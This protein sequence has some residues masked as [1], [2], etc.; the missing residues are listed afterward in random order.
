MP[1]K[2]AICGIKKADTVDHIPPRSIY[3][4]PIGNEFQLKTI[5]ACKTCNN[6]S[7]NEDEQF[8]MWIG[9]A[10]GQF[11]SNSEKI[12]NSMAATMSNNNTLRDQIFKSQKYIYSTYRS[13]IAEPAIPIKFN[14]Q[15]I[16][17][18][19]KRIIRGLYWI[20]KGAAL[21]KNYSV[22]VT[23]SSSLTQ[24]RRTEL[25][26]I[27]RESACKHLNGDTFLYQARF[28]NDDTPSS[29]WFIQFFNVNQTAYFAEIQ[30]NN[31]PQQD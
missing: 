5:P 24:F 29:L 1:K 7:S 6:G 22:I 2:C 8:K 12:I 3:P 19:I 27:L 26:L 16:E 4:R 25:E 23:Q 30:E 18:V 14:Q 17:R 11:R 9:A 28:N 31:F 21:G 10:T 13:Q 15:H 20:E